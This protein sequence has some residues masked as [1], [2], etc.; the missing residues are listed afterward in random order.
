MV[1]SAIRST[2]VHLF[3]PLSHIGRQVRS[4]LSKNADSKERKRFSLMII[5]QDF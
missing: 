1:T 5:S 3:V 4:R 2:P